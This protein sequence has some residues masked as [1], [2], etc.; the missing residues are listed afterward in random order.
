MTPLAIQHS[1]LVEFLYELMRDKLPF[2]V[3]ERL[4]RETEQG[5]CETMSF[6]NNHLAAYAVELANRLIADPPRPREAL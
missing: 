6:T 1:K 3:V 5:N 4:V 2:G